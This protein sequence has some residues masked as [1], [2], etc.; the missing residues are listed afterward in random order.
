M[1]AIGAFY[2]QSVREFGNYPN[3]GIYAAVK[4]KRLRGFFKLSNFNSIAMPKDYYLLYA[5]P[6]NPFS[7]NFGISWEFYD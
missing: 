6:D 2:L 7:F 1:P 3:A 5:I 4:I